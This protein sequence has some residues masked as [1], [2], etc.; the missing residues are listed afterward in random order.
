[1]A[2]PDPAALAA[3]L[4]RLG[5]QIDAGRAA[6]VLA[7]LPPAWEV[8]MGGG[9]RSIST[10][11][12]RKLLERPATGAG[13]AKAW[14]EYLAAHLD[15]YSQAPRAT[16]DA[17]GKLER[18]LGR[19]EF[20]G[21]GPPSAWELWRQRMAAWVNDLLRRIFASIP[22]DS[23]AGAILTWVLLAG[24]VGAAG[25]LLLRLWMRDD[26]AG[27]LPADGFRARARTSYDWLRAAREAAAQRDWRG[28]VQCAYWAGIAGLEETGAL[29][30]DRT[31]TPRE[32]L[33]LLAPSS[34]DAASPLAQ[35]LAEL[36]T[37]LER[38]WY[39]RS[40]A[41]AEDFAACL[42]SLEAMGCRVK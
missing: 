39:A 9:Q 20:A 36:T 38:F 35:P 4:R 13:A 22:A 32:Y 15:G 24:T 5:A 31:H 26:P 27:L 37:R 16:R 3:E 7:A 28:A 34:P 25:F 10:A 42:K 19:R 2:A 40:S 8:D 6:P 11:P 18:I 17:Q 23:T 30:C 1:M 29:P 21:I 12:L 41:G 33:R 14:L